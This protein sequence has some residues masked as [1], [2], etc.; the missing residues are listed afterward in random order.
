M[1]RFLS[2][3]KQYDDVKNKRNKEASSPFLVYSTLRDNVQIPNV[4]I[5]M[6]MS[7]CDVATINRA[8]DNSRL[9][10]FRSGRYKTLPIP[11]DIFLQSLHIGMRLDVFSQDGSWRTGVIVDMEDDA[12]LLTDSDFFQ[13]HGEQYC[14]KDHYDN[15]KCDHG[16]N[17]DVD[18]HTPAPEGPC[19]YVRYDNDIYNGQDDGWNEWICANSAYLK[20]FL[21][22]YEGKDALEDLDWS[23]YLRPGMMYAKP[24]L[25]KYSARIEQTTQF[26]GQTFGIENQLPI[27]ESRN[28]VLDIHSSL[29]IQNAESGAILH[30]YI[31]DTH[32]SSCGYPYCSFVAMTCDDNGRI[33]ALT[34]PCRHLVVITLLPHGAGISQVRYDLHGILPCQ[35]R[36][37]IQHVALCM[38]IHEDTMTLDI[39][40]IEYKE[41]PA[42]RQT[43]S[44]ALPLLPSMI[45]VL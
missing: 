34:R 1:K 15:D 13:W 44:L 31:L 43:Y 7:Y 12:S 37:D 24:Y 3:A 9:L 38:L 40:E 2:D 23:T 33:Y 17:P 14:D 39:Q 4:L 27:C 26:K 25:D 10:P 36:Q 19:V 16:F 41:D 20:P 32:F 35:R 5:R 22:A 21:S 8:L 6:I 18:V 11:P 42:V 29:V 28:E 45:P 30:Q